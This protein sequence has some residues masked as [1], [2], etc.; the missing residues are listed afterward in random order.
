VSRELKKGICK[1]LKGDMEMM[2]HQ[3]ENINKEKYRLVIPYPKC[4]E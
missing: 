2:S 1:E 4:L 3:I